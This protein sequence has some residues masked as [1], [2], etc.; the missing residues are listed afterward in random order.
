MTF[1]SRAISYPM[2]MW[3][4]NW[5]RQTKIYKEYYSCF[6]YD[7]CEWKKIFWTFWC[8]PPNWTSIGGL[9]W[10]MNSESDIKCN[11]RSFSPCTYYSSPPFYSIIQSEQKLLVLF[12]CRTGFT[13]R[14]DFFHRVFTGFSG[15]NRVLNTRSLTA[16]AKGKRRINLCHR[17]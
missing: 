5:F 1:N 7:K 4:K 12:H 16:D 15:R 8:V 17:H 14:I 2:M 13:D 9:I 3:Q 6:K 11:D 10:T